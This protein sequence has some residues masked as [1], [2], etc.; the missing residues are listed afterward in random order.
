M[1]L[2]QTI[3]EQAV[4]GLEIVRRPEDLDAIW[5]AGVAAALW[6]RTPLPTFQQWLDGLHPDHLPSARVVLRPAAVRNAVASLCHGAGTP[7]GPER[8]MLVDDIAAL[9]DIFA[10]LSGAPYLRLRLDR[11]SGNA[12]GRFHV[13]AV[14]VRLICT[15]RGTGTE[16]GAGQGGDVPR[17]V[18][19]A[20]TGA[21][22]L[23]RGKLW[24]ARGTSEL[25]HRSPPVEG[26]G[27]TRLVLVLDPVADP[28]D[29][30]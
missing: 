21:P 24:P 6:H 23:L 7:P 30:A 12:C 14:T 27:E 17:E 22:L 8:D 11:V 20:P 29:A 2:V 25:L 3:T 26:T 10:A 4:A 5:Q 1:T 9:A 28:E 19:N 16:Y 15:Y 18:F 13:D